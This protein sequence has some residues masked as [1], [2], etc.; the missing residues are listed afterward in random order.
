MY[1]YDNIWISATDLAQ[2]GHFTWFS[3]GKVVSYSAWAIGQPFRADPNYQFD[4]F[5]QPLPKE[6]YENTED[7]VQIRGETRQWENA[8]CTDLNYF[9]CERV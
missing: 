3:T 1:D 5:G 6:I 9:L 2:E 4:D 7:C 8:N